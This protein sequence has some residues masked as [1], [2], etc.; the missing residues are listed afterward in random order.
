MLAKSAMSP[1]DI[2]IRAAQRAERCIGNA[3]HQHGKDCDWRV[4]P[5]LGQVKRDLGQR[6][7]CGGRADRSW[8]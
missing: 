6:E 3:D 8:Q 5:E 1:S 7:R 4:P 2:P